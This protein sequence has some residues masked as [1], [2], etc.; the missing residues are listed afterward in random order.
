MPLFPIVWEPVSKGFQRA[1]ETEIDGQLLP[2]SI[3]LELR[4]LQRGLLFG[5]RVKTEKPTGSEECQEGISCCR[6]LSLILLR[7]SSISYRLDLTRELGAR[8]EISCQRS[9]GL[10]RRGGASWREENPRGKGRKVISH[11]GSRSRLRRGA[12]SECRR[13]RSYGS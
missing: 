3:T 4:A 13:P 8:R 5:T 9:G 1:L 6:G 11:R 7:P 10:R 12:T 2:H